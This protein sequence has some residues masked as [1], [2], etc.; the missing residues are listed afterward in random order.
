MNIN[1]IA[2][3]CVPIANLI[4]HQ[5]DLLLTWTRLYVDIWYDEGDE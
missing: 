4:A 2:F 5:F 1:D 3:G